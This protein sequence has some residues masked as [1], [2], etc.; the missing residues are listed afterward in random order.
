M[1]DFRDKVAVITVA[2][3][4]IWRG[5]ADRGVQEG[6]KLVLADIEAPALE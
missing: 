5:L 2:A 1:K 3:S 4:G 6:M